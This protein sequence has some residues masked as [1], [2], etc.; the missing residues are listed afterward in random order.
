MILRHLIRRPHIR[1]SS[2]TGILLLALLS[3]PLLST[4]ANLSAQDGPTTRFQV[5]FP[6]ESFSGAVTGRVFVMISRTTEREP[7]LQIGRDGTP[8]FGQD[9]VG[10]EPGDAGIID[11]TTLGSPVESL[12]DLPP[13]EYYVQGMVNIY[14]EFQRSDGHTLWMHDDQWEGQAF[15]RSPGNLYSAV[16][17][18]RLDP[19]MGYDIE[20]VADNVIPPIEFPEDTE[21]VK[22]FRFQSRI[23]TEFWGQPIYLGATVLLPR[24]YEES[25][26]SYPVLYRQGHFSTG[27][28]L[29]FEEGGDLYEEWVEDDFPRMLV[30]TFQ[31]PAPYFDDS[32]AVN[33][34]NVGPYG[35]AIMEELITEVED[36]FRIIKEPWARWLD[37]G[38]TGGWESLALQLFHPDFFGGVWSYCP[39]PVTF[40]NVEGIN[41]YEDENAYYKV[42][43]WRHVPTVNSRSPDGT[44]RMTSR[45]RN[46]YELA[47]GT[48][49]RSGEQLD[50]WSAVNGPIGDDGYFKPLFDKRTGEI[51]RGVAE[52][53]RE[54]YDL[55]EYM[56]R[57]WSW[58]GEKL[59]DKIHIYIGDMDTY[60]LEQAVFELEAWMETTTNPH[61][62]GFF[63]Y[64]D[65]KPHCWSGPVSTPERLKE[66]AQH[67]LRHKPEGTTTPWWRY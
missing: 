17:R 35:D 63:M 37:G 21:W 62:P 61:V 41:A 28:P 48:K 25:T 14:T 43:G 33:S 34:V 10:L 4:G 57:N 2:W 32:Y 52:Y 8:F 55:L 56:K 1:S 27:A 31:H 9:V 18:V 44:M 47:K 54:N 59:E 40:T 58:L 20:L 46:Y 16:Q 39:D 29:R 60:R 6:A 13:G 64:G 23:L 5:S 22:R 7:R 19:E 3:A 50:I 49:G 11:G 65:R 26:I 42:R 53:W 12:S 67:G 30:V 51:D 66:M 36:R 24:N 15:Q 38:S 45:Q